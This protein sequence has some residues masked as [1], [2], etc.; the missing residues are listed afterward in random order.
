MKAQRPLTPL[1]ESPMPAY[2]TGLAVGTG[3]A[4]IALLLLLGLLNV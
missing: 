3:S 4:V 1:V 2:M